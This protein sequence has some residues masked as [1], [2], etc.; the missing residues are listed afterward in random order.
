M[1]LGKVPVLSKPLQGETLVLYLAVS[2]AAVSAVLIILEDNVELPVF[3]ISRALLDLETRY[4]DTKKIALALIVAARK[5]RPY[6]QAHAILV[7]T[8]ASLR[9]ILQNPEC[10]GR[11]SK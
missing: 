4:P 5:L 3:Y 2:E 6:F 7:Y 1:Y 11:L 8:K 9:Q 10:T